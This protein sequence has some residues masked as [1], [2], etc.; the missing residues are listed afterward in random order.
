MTNLIALFLGVLVMG[1]TQASATAQ[2]PVRGFVCDGANVWGKIEIQ[3]LIVQSADPSAQP[4]PPY[5]SFIQ[6]KVRNFGDINLR[7]AGQVDFFKQPVA[8]APEGT[9]QYNKQ[10]AIYNLGGS[11]LSLNGRNENLRLEVTLIDRWH[12]RARLYIGHRDADSNRYHI[13]DTFFDSYC[14][15]HD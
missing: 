3:G 4:F 8:G 12:L 13:D 14:K 2:P 15:L 1:P 5:R 7:H 11:E 10:T 6:L 9:W